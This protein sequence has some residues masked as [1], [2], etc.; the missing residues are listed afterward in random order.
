MSISTRAFVLA[1]MAALLAP[2]TSTSEDTPPPGY[3]V[4]S[5]PGSAVVTGGFGQCW[6]TS[7]WDSKDRI[8]KCDPDAAAAE[9]TPAAATPPQQAAVPAPAPAPEPPKTAQESAPPVTQPVQPE[10]APAT[11]LTPPPAAAAAP[12]NPRLETALLPQTVTIRR[13]RFSISTNLPCDRRAEQR[14]MSW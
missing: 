13:M 6:H 12:Q 7:Y 9:K 5:Y 2:G 3:V 10:E 1:G 11:P 14:S 8:D 4:E